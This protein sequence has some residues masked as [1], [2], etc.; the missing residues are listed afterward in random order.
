[1]QQQKIEV[2]DTVIKSSGGFERYKVLKIHGLMV[3]AELVT[4]SKATGESV[5]LDRPFVEELPFDILIK[6]PAPE[7]P[8]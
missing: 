2:G 3:T 8:R 1:M 5:R 6:V 7:D 4:R